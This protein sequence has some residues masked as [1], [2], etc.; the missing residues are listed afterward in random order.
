VIIKKRLNQFPLI[1]L[2]L[3]IINR[4]IQIIGSIS[5]L[6]IIFLTFYYFNSGMY[7]RYKPLMLLKKIDKII[8]NK[9][10]GFSFFEIDDYISQNINSLKF[11]FY[12]ND[13]E[14]VTLKINQKNLYNLESQRKNKIEGISEKIEKFSRASLDYNQNDFD[15][16]LRVKGDRSLHW[17]DQN[18]T[19]YKIDLRGD[20]RIWGLEEFSVQKP[21]TRNY[22]YEF[23]FHKLL[24]ENKL[25]ALKYF[26]I[27]L[28]LNDTNLGIYAVEEGFSKELVERNKRRNGP[29]F[30]V[31]ELK[32][33][34]YPNIEYDLYSKNY[35]QSNYSQ[36]IENASL[37]LNEIKKINNNIDNIFDLE[38]WATYFSIIDLTGNFHGSIPKSV[39]LFYN[40]V[41][42]KFEPIGFDG[43][44]NSNLFQN[45]LIL[46]FLDIKNKNC[47][48]ICSEREWY[49]RFLQNT[50]FRNIYFKK[51]KEISSEKFIKKF[52]ESNI[53][54]INF[55]NDQFLSDTSK[56]DKIF[57]KGIGLY[58]FNKNYLF[59]RSKYIQSRI[60]EIESKLASK[61]FLRNQVLEEN[62]LLNKKEIK[63]FE[64]N[65][66]LNNDIIIDRNLYLESDKI[67]NIQKGVKILFI[68]DVTLRS[69]G[70]IF[71]N[72]T[73]EK[74]IIVYSNDNIGSIILSNNNFKLNN[75]IF[76]NLSY[77]KEKDKIL[78][79]GINIINSDVEI[80]DSHIASSNSE[81]AINIISS[82]SFIRNLRVNDIKADAIDIDFGNLNFTNITCE[83][84]NNDC[85]DV[86]G[87]N[88]TGNFFKGLNIKD[89]G[90]SFGENAKGE[91]SHLNIKNSKLGV[92]VKDGSNLKL[93]KYEFKN[94][95]FDVVVFNKKKEY[96]GGSLII[97]NPINNSQLNYLIGLNNSIVKDQN[98]LTKKINNK[99]IN[100]LFY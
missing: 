56:K 66:I 64:N 18:S 58:I 27:N 30:G 43:H 16:R 21:I 76:K 87:A 100:Q 73:K 85:L 14:N 33:V 35:W 29:I 7:E 8:I 23:I 84:I 88:V 19:S 71:F 36:L 65:F 6:I 78:Y 96:E 57:Y 38:K 11:I 50:K 68:K 89:K 31:E 91:I 22:I 79:G 32:S 12:K 28:S 95:D 54:K 82:N 25:I 93:S 10:L 9:Y 75:V 39:K 60:A 92:A 5:L 53:K 52:Y 83:N 44:Y 48:Y 37:K 20:D 26:F 61:S 94:N 72:G 40:P 41:T 62:N 81:D 4:L 74:P 63:S 2:I 13:L 67:L 55:Y 15:I 70:S 1:S 17:F 46:D 80:I 77:P 98:I 99:I 42:A 51:L 59:E 90:L 45:F 47:S 49:L 97:D 86:S 3:K 24:E 34:N 69:E